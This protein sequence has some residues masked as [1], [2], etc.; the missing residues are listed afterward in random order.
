MRR[1]SSVPRKA[2]PEEFSCNM[3]VCHQALFHQENAIRTL[4][5]QYHFSPI[6]IVQDR[7]KKKAA[8]FTKTQLTIIT[9][10]KKA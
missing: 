6:L 2:D 8:C 7:M 10:W 3:L 1:P 5:P 9:I 4:R